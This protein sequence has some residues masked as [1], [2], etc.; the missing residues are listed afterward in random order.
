MGNSLEAGVSGLRAHQDMLDVVGNNLANINT[1]GFKASRVTFADL[2]SET[3]RTG[4]APTATL[5]GTNPNQI[6]QGV[7]VG[8]IEQDMRQGGLQTTGR[9]LDLSLEGEGYFVLSDGTSDMYSRVGTFGIDSDNTLV[10]TTSGLRVQSATGEDIVIDVDS[11]LPAAA[12]TEVNFTGNLDALASPPVAAQ[13]ATPPLS[14]GAPATVSG[15]NGAPFALADGQQFT[16]RANGQAAE[17]VTFRAVDFAAIGAATAAEVAAAINAQLSGVVASD[18]GGTVQLAST[19][20]G[21]GSSLDVDDGVGNPAFTLG[22]STTLTFGTEVP[23]TATTQLN[24]LP[25][26]SSD[27]V[28]GDIIDVAGLD[29]DGTPVSA[30]FVYGTGVGQNGTTLGDLTA[31]VQGLYPG[32]TVSIATNG[33]V[34]IDAVAVGESPL[35]LTLTDGPV[36]AGFTSYSSIPYATTVEGNDGAIL[37]TSIEV[38]DAQGSPHA[39]LFTLHKTAPNQWEVTATLP[40]GDGTLLDGDVQGVRFND[41]GSFDFVSGIGIGDPNIEIVWAGTTATQ[42][43][44]LDFGANGEFSGLTQFG[45]AMTAGATEQDGFGFGTLSSLNVNAAGEIQGVYTNGQIQ[46]LDQLGITTFANPA[47]LSKIGDSLLAASP[48]SGAPTPGV[49][50][51]GRAG[52]VV[53]GALEGSNVDIALEFTRLITAQRGFQVNSRT[54]TTTD[55]MLQELA[56]LIR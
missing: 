25:Q 56:N 41:D 12:S 3:V 46:V 34:Q 45:G 33:S 10:S 42:T 15:A 18:V 6:G 28:P 5:G 16:L 37:E 22:L 8:S 38:I 21:N 9:S 54:I 1:P 53:A 36:N 20:T 26:N 14:E 19:Q 39:V 27:Y 30:T 51:S 48:S 13:I 24:D 11:T 17:V 31:F 44:T 50:L 7:R 35:Q 52:K 32:S 23:A 49:A 29:A 43:I 40:D 2:I 4:T 47:G 55:Q